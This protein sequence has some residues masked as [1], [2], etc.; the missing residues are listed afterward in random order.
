MADTAVQEARREITAQ[1]DLLL[2]QQPDR[3]DLLLIRQEPP[4]PGINTDKDKRHTIR[5][6]VQFYITYFSN[7]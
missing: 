5:Y 1:E 6:A 7:A 3:E 4:T 2:L